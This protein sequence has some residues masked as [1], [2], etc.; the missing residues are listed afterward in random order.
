MVPRNGPAT[1]LVNEAVGAE[2]IDGGQGVVV[3]Q[4]VE[5]PQR[6]HE[7]GVDS[8]AIRARQRQRGCLQLSMGRRFGL[9]V[10]LCSME[11]EEREE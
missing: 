5:E 10:E 1:R 3:V 4:L 2:R 6:Q 11:E 7:R 8:G 9:A